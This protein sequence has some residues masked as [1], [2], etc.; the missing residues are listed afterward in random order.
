MAKGSSFEREIC[1]SLSLW[2][3]KDDPEPSDAV[4]WRTSNSGGRATVRGKAGKRTRNHYGDIMAVDPV[5]QPLIDFITW[6]IKRGYSRC[7]LADL[8]DSPPKA[9]KQEWQKWIEQASKAAD[10]AGA[11]YWAIIARRDRREPILVLPERL[12]DS[13]ESS[14]IY[15]NISFYRHLRLTVGDRVI[16]AVP[17]TVFTESF[18]PV[19]IRIRMGKA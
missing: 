15:G 13:F 3:T 17:L 12:A 2:W 8:L 5:G 11:L 6:E 18:D 10:D 4:F 1:R 19:W 9:A 7:S 16:H 14:I